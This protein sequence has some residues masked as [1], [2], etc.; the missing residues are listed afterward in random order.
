[1][2]RAG[3][4]DRIS[5]TSAGTHGYHVGEPPDL[6]AQESA[7][8]RGYDLSVQRARKV[9]P[10]DFADFDL[11][12]P[13]DMENMDALMRLRPADARTEPELF[14][15]YVAEPGVGRRAAKDVKDPYYGSAEGFDVM[16]D[17]IEE[18]AAKLLALLAPSKV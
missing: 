12:L 5:C 11:I 2:Q 1:V 14:L 13:M 17:V 10:E 8:R 18:G 15:E 3:L 9:A 7:R 4:Q 6:R 16:L